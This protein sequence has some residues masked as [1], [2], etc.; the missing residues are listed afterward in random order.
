MTGS[1]V[2]LTGA[3]GVG[4]TTIADVIEKRHPECAVFHFDTVGVPSAEIMATFGLGHEPGGAWQ[5]AMTLQWF[6]RIGPVLKTGRAVLFEGQMRIAFVQEAKSPMLGS[7]S[8]S[9]TTQPAFP[10]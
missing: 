4:K 8:W 7:L 9:A 6:K 10:G 1:L 5:R 3:S 2:V